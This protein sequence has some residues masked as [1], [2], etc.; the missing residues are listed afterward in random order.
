MMPKCFRLAIVIE[1]AMAGALEVSMSAQ[2]PAPGPNP[3]GPTASNSPLEQIIVTGYVVPH[4]GEGAQPV[5][6]LDRTFIDQQGDQTVSDVLQRLPQN[7]G[8]FTPQVSAGTSFSPAASAVNLQGL[9]VNS[10]LVLIDGHRQTA[11]PF[12]QNGFQTFTDL[13]AIP[14]AAVDRIEVLRD[15]ASAIYGSDAIAGVVNIIFKDEY[16][17]GDII[18]TYGI[19]QPGDS[20][21]YH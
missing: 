15:G 17:C 10:T 6:T 14:L 20:E 4:V 1:L 16:N 2:A 11:F 9:G 3:A 12:P 21:I 18:G 5:T 7:V 19:S 8:G 13:N